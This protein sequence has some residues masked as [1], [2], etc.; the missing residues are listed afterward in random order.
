MI[1]LL[2]AGCIITATFIP[3]AIKEDRKEGQQQ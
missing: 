3:W 1:A 2:L